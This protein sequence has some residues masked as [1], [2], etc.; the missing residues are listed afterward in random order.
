MDL[1]FYHRSL[2]G[3]SSALNCG[4]S[5]DIVLRGSMGESSRRAETPGNVRL[6]NEDVKRAFG[7]EGRLQYWTCVTPEKRFGP[8]SVDILRSSRLKRFQF[9]GWSHVMK[10]HEVRKLT[11][12]WCRKHRTIIH[13]TKLYMSSPS[14]EVP[15]RG[16]SLCEAVGSLM[17]F[18]FTGQDSNIKEGNPSCTVCFCFL[19]G[20]QGGGGGWLGTFSHCLWLHVLK[21]R[22]RIAGES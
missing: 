17:L 4:S 6:S 11:R 15:L 3:L 19:S 9:T 22:E 2:E 16:G 20:Q 14:W 1:W 7:D 18:V 8:Y 21:R 5:P 12:S 13:L 10:H